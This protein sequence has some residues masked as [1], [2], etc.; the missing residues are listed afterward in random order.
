LNPLFTEYSA[1]RTNL[2]TALVDAFQ[3]NL[4]QGNRPLNGFEIGRVFWQQEES[5][6][7]ADAIAGILGGDPMQGK[8]MR[9]IRHEQPMTWFEAKGVLESAFERLG[10]LVEYQ[11]DRRDPRLHPGRT[12]SLWLQGNRLGVFG[13]LHPQLRQARGLPEAVYAFEL[14]LD[15]ALAF[16]EQKQAEHAVFQPYSTYPA[17]DRDIAFFAP[18]EISVAE[19]ERVIRK[20]AGDLMKSVELFDEY[21]GEAVPVG[22]RSLGFRLIYRASDRTLSDQEVEPIHQKVRGVL[23][24]KLNVSLRS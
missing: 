7:E 4:E 13:Q 19:I 8:W 18:I 10:L 21:R 14:D 5:H 2:I 15:T 24:E 23:V 20:A 12:A 16:M 6:Q 1:L 22:Q 17:V 3:Y 11:P 9:G